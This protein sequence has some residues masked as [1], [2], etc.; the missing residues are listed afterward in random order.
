MCG[1]VAHLVKD[2][3]DKLERDSAPA[4]RP[5]NI[6]FLILTFSIH[7]HPSPVVSLS[8]ETACQVIRYS[9]FISYKDRNFVPCMK[10][11]GS[12]LHQ[13]ANSLSSVGTILRTISMKSLKAARI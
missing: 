7:D 9:F 3:P 2:C 8:F 4:K 11:Q 5:S 13:E 12:M 10:R 6:S 1:S